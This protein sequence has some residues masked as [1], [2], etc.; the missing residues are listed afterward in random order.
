M[1]KIGLVIFGSIIALLITLVVFD[2]LNYGKL[3]DMVDLLTNMK[4]SNDDSSNALTNLFKNIG[5]T[6]S[7]H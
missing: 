7:Y 6:G 1:N 5:A 2:I 3:S 4:Q